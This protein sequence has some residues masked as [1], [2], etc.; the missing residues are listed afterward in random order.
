MAGIANQKLVP[1]F[2]DSYF[3]NLVPLP[4]NPF[5]V[6]KY[7]GCYLSPLI[8]YFCPLFCKRKRLKNALIWVGTHNISTIVTFHSS[9]RCPNLDLLAGGQED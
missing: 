7:N 4:V 3:V 8:R 9:R 6:K 5:V 1:L 2:V